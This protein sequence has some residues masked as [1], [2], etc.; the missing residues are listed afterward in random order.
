MNESD[1]VGAEFPEEHV[2][3]DQVSQSELILF[4]LEH[5]L[6][7]INGELEGL[8]Q[9]NHHFDVLSKVC[10]SLEE[11]DELDATHLFWDERIGNKQAEHLQHARKQMEAFAEKIARVEGSR[12]AVVEKIG[13]HAAVL[14]IAI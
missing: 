10:R 4:R 7:E 14:L 13:D 6:R 5:E 11:L 8:T 12:Q 2:I 1:T 9:R 3:R